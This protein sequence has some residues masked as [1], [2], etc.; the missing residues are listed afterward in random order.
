MFLS[1]FCKFRPKFKPNYVQEILEVPLVCDIG[2]QCCGKR[3]TYS[4][5]K[6]I[7]I[8]LFRTI[9]VHI[10]EEAFGYLTIIQAKIYLYV[11]VQI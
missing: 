6:S 5:L 4:F 9:H 8:K 7:Q 10:Q 3:M 1:S 2:I 11:N